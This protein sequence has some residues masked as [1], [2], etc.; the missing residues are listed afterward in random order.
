MATEPR[1]EGKSF[2][3]TE[4]GTLVESFQTNL[5]VVAE[6]VR[7]FSDWRERVESKLT[8]I[9]ERLIL[10]EDRLSGVEYQLTGM[11]GR[12]TRV[13]NVVLESIPPLAKRVAKLEAKAGI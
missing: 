8:G 1:K 9:E 12:L 4:V 5:S 3:A 11:G 2:S 13:E 7:G 6:E 10:V